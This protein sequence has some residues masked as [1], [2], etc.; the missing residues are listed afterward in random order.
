M[1]IRCFALDIKL[2]S[3]KTALNY[4]SMLFILSLCFLSNNI[5]MDYSS[6]DNY[7]KDSAFDKFIRLFINI[8]S[9]FQESAELVRI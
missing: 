3:Y 4:F 7:S 1:L 5:T 2:C 8:I 9:D 6:I